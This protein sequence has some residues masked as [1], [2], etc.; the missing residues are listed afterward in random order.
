MK[1]PLSTYLQRFPV[2]SQI[3]SASPDPDV[4]FIV[5]IPCRNEPELRFTLKSLAETNQPPSGYKVEVL[6]GFNTHPSDGDQIQSL[7]HSQIQHFQNRNILASWLESEIPAW[8]NL[9]AIQAPDWAPKAAGV[10]SARKLLMDEALR[11]FQ[12]LQRPD[13]WILCLDADCLCDP[14][15]FCAL[16]AALKSHPEATGAHAFFEHQI[17]SSMGSREVEAI[18]LYELGLRY[19]RLALLQTGFPQAPHTVGSCMMSRVDAYA[20][21]GGMNR[22]QAG[23]DFYFVHK[24][25]QAGPFIHLN[26]CKVHPS[27]R[28]SDRVPFGTGKAVGDML[29][30][31]NPSIPDSPVWNVEPFV[32]FRDLGVFFRSMETFFNSVDPTLSSKEKPESMNSCV[33]KFNEISAQWSP[34][35]KAFVN[36][37]NG[38]NHVQRI[39][40]STK[41]QDRAGMIRRFYHW[42]DGFMCMKFLRFVQEIHGPQPVQKAAIDL[43]QSLKLKKEPDPYRLNLEQLLNALKRLDHESNEQILNAS[44]PA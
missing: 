41:N 21:V 8:M 44:L 39:L 24:L 4:H 28:I 40:R 16:E 42:F 35:M 1:E 26:D 11:R 27:G 18:Q 23:E 29:N 6:V 12:K 33:V 13:G 9:F 3:L 2:H 17:H 14:A 34:A 30:N 10:G 37:R 22:R 19:Y 36:S 25:I 7:H 15:Y 5:T 38:L 43:I 31:L 32:G 20:R